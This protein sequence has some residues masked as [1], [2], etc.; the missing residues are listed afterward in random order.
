MDQLRISLAEVKNTAEMIRHCN[1]EIYEDLQQARKLM[2]DLAGVWQSDGSEAIR[3]RFNHFAAQFDV[4]KQII[5]AYA[6]F[7]DMT[8]S[9]YDTLES[10]IQ[11]N[12][13]AFQ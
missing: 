4:Q 13:G 5:D 8:V 12:A 6:R 9:S 3:Q 7:L 10:T 1:T 2:N 11:T